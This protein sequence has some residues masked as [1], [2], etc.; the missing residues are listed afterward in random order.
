MP[1]TR[2]RRPFAGSL[3]AL[4]AIVASG[5]PV[6]ERAEAGSY[7][8]AVCQTS[9]AALGAPTDGWS[10]SNGGGWTYYQNYC[11]SGGLHV[12][13]E[14]TVHHNDGDYASWS[15]SAP[16]DTSI[17]HLWGRVE[18][19]TGAGQAYGSPTA[20]IYSSQG[21]L[22]VLTPSSRTRS[23][24]FGFYGLNATA[25]GFNVRCSGSNGCPAESG[26]AWMGMSRLQVGYDDAHA[27]N[28]GTTSG[29]LLAAGP[30]KDTVSLSYTATDRGGGLY[31]T[32]LSVDGATR[33]NTIIDTNGGR[34]RPLEGNT[35]F[36]YRVPC[37]LSAS[38]TVSL[39]TRTLSE[40]AHNVAVYSYDAGHNQTTVHAAT[41]V[42]DNVPPPA[43]TALPTVT[44]RALTGH[45]LTGVRGAWTGT[46]V[47]YAYRWQRRDG[48]SWEDVPGATGLT[49][50]LGLEDGGHRMRLTVK[51]TNAEGTTEASSDPTATVLVVGSTDPTTGDFDGDGLSNAIDPDDDGDGIP[52]VRD[53]AP[54]DP[55][56]GEA[57]R[58]PEPV[59]SGQDGSTGQSGQSGTNGSNGAIAPG[60]AGGSGGTG[61]LGGAATTSTLPLDR[62]ALNGRTGSG[63]A[64][65]A[66]AFAGSEARIIRITY[67]RT[68]VIRGTLRHLSG[69]EISGATLTVLSRPLV[70]GA[71]LV[72]IA[73]IV[74][75]GQ[76]R[77]QYTAPRGAGR[78]IRIGYRLMTKDTT[79]VRT[80]DVE[81]QVRPRV[82][83]TPRR[84]SLRNGQ[85]V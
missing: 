17:S 75:D 3:V 74:T 32:V 30:K 22:D 60:G 39:D 43:N 26:K 12:S 67:G 19:L 73:Q 61:G 13:L 8:Q 55:V 42:V 25:V 48:A 51:A 82:T 63:E 41:I 40:G 46:G 49:H 62:G 52:D 35:V 56:V 77:F 44:G 4:A 68:A 80:S 70:A 7:S 59:R 21:A 36:G 16:A 58:A 28:V 79:F 31:K 37:K 9:N 69:R 5:G 33:Q 2:L 1:S 50:R 27:P 78:L 11:S 65:L 54:F 23:Q 29:T 34:C 45:D 14:D 20:S 71:Q 81:L 47:T 76:G 72:E 6:A 38:D 66:A 53:A 15:M 57:G 10:P 18:A 64:R 84:A 24:D 83:F 85:S